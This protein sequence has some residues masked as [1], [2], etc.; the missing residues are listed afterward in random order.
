MLV[1]RCVVY[2]FPLQGTNLSTSLFLPFSFRQRFF[3]MIGSM[4]D[5]MLA[6]I[7]GYP[8]GNSHI[9]YIEDENFDDFPEVE[10][11]SSI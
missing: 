11:V 6:P 10:Y 5:G 7:L 2:K 1:F 9:P 3:E 4:V 8:P